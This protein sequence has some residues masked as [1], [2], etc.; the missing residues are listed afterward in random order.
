MCDNVPSKL[1]YNDKG[2]DRELEINKVLY[3]PGLLPTSSNHQSSNVEIESE[4]LHPETTYSKKNQ[5]T[6]DSEN[7]DKE[8]TGN[9]YVKSGKMRETINHGDY[10]NNAFR[11]DGR[12]FGDHDVSQMLRYGQNSRDVKKT[13]RDADLKDYKFHKLLKNVNDEDNVVLPF[14]RGGIDTRNLDKFRYKD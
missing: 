4:L 3:V 14:P 8:E 13:A 9:F 1:K 2:F 11:G 12:G 6:L 5:V 10:I 7:K